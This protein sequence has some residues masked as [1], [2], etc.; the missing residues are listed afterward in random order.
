[1]KNNLRSLQEY[2]FKVDLSELEKC[3]YIIIEQLTVIFDND[4]SSLKRIF[5]KLRNSIVT[6]IQEFRFQQNLKEDY[7]TLYKT[8]NEDSINLIFVE[9]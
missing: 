7:F 3:I 1:M 2:Q 8:I 9:L 5:W 4:R 6:I